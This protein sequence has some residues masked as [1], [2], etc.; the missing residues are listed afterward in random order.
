MFENDDITDLN[1]THQDFRKFLE[2]KSIDELK[3]LNLEYLRGHLNSSCY[4]LEN[5]TVS[6]FLVLEKVILI[7]KHGIITTDFNSFNEDSRICHL[8]QH[9]INHYIK[10]KAYLKLLYPKE[11]FENFKTY[12]NSFDVEILKNLETPIEDPTLIWITTCR[13]ENFKVKFIPNSFLE[14]SDFVKCKN[15]YNE[16]KEKYYEVH[17]YDPKNREN[18]MYD[19]ILDYLKIS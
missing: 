2:C 7:N 19:V 3:M 17:I 18:Y 4:N 10:Q 12:L 14:C 13:C 6:Q 9:T 15:I 8:Y 11:D 5:I 1:N 16:L